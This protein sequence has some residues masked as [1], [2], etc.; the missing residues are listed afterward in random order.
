MKLILPPGENGHLTNIQFG[1]EMSPK[2]DLLLPP[3]RDQM[4]IGF[5]LADGFQQHDGPLTRSLTALRIWSI[6]PHGQA[7]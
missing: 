2:Y 1:D 7:L 3:E 4:A 5:F 6:R